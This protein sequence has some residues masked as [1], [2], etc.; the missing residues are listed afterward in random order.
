M[1]IATGIYKITSPSGK[2]YIGQSRNILKRKKAYKENRISEQTH[3]RRSIL[4][5]GFEKHYFEIVYE[6]PSDVDQ[7]TLNEYEKLFIMFYRSAGWRMLNI[8]EGGSNGK[9]HPDTIAKLKELSKDRYL[10]EANPFYGKK[11]SPESIALISQSKKGK[12]SWN[13]GINHREDSIVKMSENRKGFQAWNKGVSL[14]GEQNNFFGRK[15]SESSLS[16]MSQSKAGEKNPMFGRVTNNK[17]VINKATGEKFLTIKKAANSI[18][19][20]YSL[21]KKKL[22]GKI[23]NNTSFRYVSA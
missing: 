6:L 14:F 10:G 3:I 21:L 13:K 5:Y 20:E 18:G 2:I 15:H 4:K 7:D 19:M 22:Q 9:H 1:E 16:K 12:L 8:K 17:E 11:H 23:K